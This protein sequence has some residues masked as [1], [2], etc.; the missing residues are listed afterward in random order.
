MRSLFLVLLVGFLSACS[1]LS[2]HSVGIKD[3]HLLPCASAPRCVSSRDTRADHKV[4]PF[5]L[6]EADTNPW[7]RVIEQ[8][9]S[10]PRTSI[11]EQTPRYLRA[12][13]VS[14]WHFYIDDLELLL[15]DDETAEVRSSARVGYYDFNVNRERVEAL[16]AALRQAG[17]LVPE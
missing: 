14:P 8:V 9:Q 3:G 15:R 7:P 1:T 4:E 13:V 16:R 6:R 11:V 12:E 5:V 2:E 10:M 17:L